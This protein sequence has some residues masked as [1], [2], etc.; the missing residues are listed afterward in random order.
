MSYLLRLVRSDIFIDIKNTQLEIVGHTSR[1]KV[2]A[3]LTYRPESGAFDEVHFEQP[4]V[5]NSQEF[6]W[7]RFEDKDYQ[8]WYGSFRGTPFGNI[9]FS[10]LSGNAIIP[11]E[12]G[13]YVVN[14]NTRKLLKFHGV[15]HQIRS[16][17][18]IPD[19]STFV[20]ASYYEIYRTNEDYELTQIDTQCS[21]D[22]IKFKSANNEYV[23]FEFEEIGDWK[24]KNG[25]LNTETWTIEVTEYN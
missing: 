14:I 9:A 6:S 3:D 24:Q 13:T 10:E 23:E 20:V 19:S 1:L 18:T 25:L 22:L 21:M 4:S 8:D 15:E 11:T 17:I 5:W 2:K 12:D 16:V 7:V